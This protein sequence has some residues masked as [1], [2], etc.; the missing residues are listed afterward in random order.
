MEANEKQKAEHKERKKRIAIITTGGTIAGSG[1]PGEAGVYEA[2]K[3]SVSEIVRSI[4]QVNYLADLV[5]IP[6]TSVDSNDITTGDYRMIRALVRDLEKDENIDGIVITHGTDTL[7]E[8]AFF[9]NLILD[10][11]KPVVMTGAMRPATATSADGPLNLYQA[12]ALAGDPRARDMGV[13]AVFSNTIYS[14]RDMIKTNSIKTDAFTHNEFG[15]MGYMQDANVFL[16]HKPFIPHT[17]L[18]AFRNTSL[19]HLPSVEIFY[20]HMESDPELL[21]W[22]LDRYDGVVL[23]GTGSGNYSRA[24]QEVVESS[25]GQCTIVRSSHLMEGTV[26]DSP[27]F[28]PNKIAIPSYKLNPHKARLLLMLCLQEGMSQ[29]KIRDIFS[30]Y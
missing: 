2:G 11:H 5:M 30:R 28:D 19:D 15:V 20:V 8:S 1:K 21:K 7:E 17:H 22:M 13:L 26:F 27:V 6:V 3:L 23:A 18:S 12:I 29:E 14:G 16:F 4:P 10:V 24:I 9:L 25:R